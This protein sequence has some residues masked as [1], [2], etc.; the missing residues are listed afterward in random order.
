MHSH[1]G[2]V[3]LPPGTAVFVADSGLMRPGHA[4]SVSAG[5]VL[6]IRSAGT[7]A[8]KARWAP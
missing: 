4:R 5:Q 8:S 7:S 3:A 6:T 1:V 2:H